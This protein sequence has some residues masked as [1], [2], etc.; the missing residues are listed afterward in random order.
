MD[1]NDCMRELNILL[2]YLKANDKDEV[3]DDDAKYLKL[4][5]NTIAQLKDIM[6][7]F[8]YKIFE[9]RGRRKIHY[10]SQYIKIR[11]LYTKT[12]F[13]RYMLAKS[14]VERTYT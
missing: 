12:L 2:N 13:Y 7:T 9:K 3:F 11:W 5:D 6:E 14:K 8:K 1:S 4:L 10:I